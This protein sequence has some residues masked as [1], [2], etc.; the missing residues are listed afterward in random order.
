MASKKKSNK[1]GDNKVNATSTA[2]AK[3]AI[4][5]KSDGK[6]SVLDAAAQVL[7]Q[8]REPMNCQQI[9]EKMLAQKLWSTGGKT[10]A[11]TL[12]SA[13]LREITSKGKDSRFQK[14]D[15]GLFSLA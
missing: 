11:A 1:S 14:K 8:S 7:K 2:K 9:V 6:L 10:P 15:R 3:I 4:K 5:T 13:L 12:S